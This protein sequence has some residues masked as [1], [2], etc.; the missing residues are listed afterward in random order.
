MDLKS[1]T[2]SMG[3]SFSLIGIMSWVGFKLPTQPPTKPYIISI[4]DKCVNAYKPPEKPVEPIVVAKV[5]RAVVERERPETIEE[6]AHRRS[7]EVFGV[8]HWN[9]LNRLVMVESGWN[10]QAVNKSSYA[11][12][13]PQCLPV[14][15]CLAVYPDFKTNPRS[16][17]EWMLVNYIKPR[18]GTPTNA[19]NFWL[20]QRP[21]WY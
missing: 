14:S 1:L 19:L 16:Q 12:G 2:M 5:E 4:G 3:M 21:H 9:S 7:D 15:K 11:W 6:Y 13:L 17:I 20:N 8:G 18:Y 10:Y